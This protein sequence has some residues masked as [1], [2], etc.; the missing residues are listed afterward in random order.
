MSLKKL[1]EKKYS[2]P[3]RL[4]YGKSLAQEWDYSHHVIPPITTSSTFRLDSTQ[5]GAQGFGEIGQYSDLA[6]PP[7][8]VYDRMGEPTVDML[9]HALATAE[10]KEVAVAFATGMAA[11]HAGVCFALES[12]SE[13]ISHDTIY[14]CTYSLFTNWLPKLGVKVHFC[15]LT[16]PDSFLPYVNGRTRVLYLESPVNPNLELLDTEAIVANL[17]PINAKRQKDKRILT[18]FDNTF[19][20]P[21]CQ[22]P[23][24]QGI[25]VI[26]HSLTK[27][28]N[29][30]GTDMGGAVI[31]Q[32]EYFQQLVHF[33]KDF[34]GILAPT[35][36]WH[37]LVYGVS[38][39]PLRIP[40]QQSSAMKIA[41]FLESHPLVEKVRYPGLPSFPQFEVAQRLL[42]DYDGNFA[43]GII[44][45]FTLKG[46][47]P[48]HSKK[49][50][51]AMMNYVAQNS[52]SITLAVSLGQLRTLIEH[53]GSMTHASY[54][55][56]D[57]IA[58]GIDPG[59]IR[60]AVGIENANDIIADLKTALDVIS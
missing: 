11:V 34:G 42:R 14:G 12:Q 36:A 13:I 41:E 21:Y 19:A 30:F 59:G 54:A 37:I 20:T 7:I 44:I 17:Q 32:R 48:E 52:Y 60:L 6:S 22:R 15:D 16:K 10:E 9:Q 4:I 28:L 40:R 35:T 56:A 23:G 5:R 53:P 46:D 25:D 43:P 18:V 24:K 8:Y 55:A 33:R 49:R 26:I 51:E 57:Q 38:T 3:T 39:L 27:G 47:K 50:G 1:D 31:T 58:L 2:I 29:G 45:Y